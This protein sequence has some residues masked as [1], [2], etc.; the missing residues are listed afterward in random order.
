MVKMFYDK[1]NMQKPRYLLLFGDGSYDNRKLTNTNP[2]Y[3]LTY[4]S[5]NSLS[6]TNSYV[7]DDFFG[8]LDENEGDAFLTGKVD[9]GIGRFP[10]RTEDEAIAILNKIKHYSSSASYGEWKNTIC[11]IADDADK[12][13]TS[14]MNQANELSVYVA[15]NYKFLNIEKIYLDA[16]PQ[17]S[18]A[19]GQRYTEIT[20]ATHI[21]VK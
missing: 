5:K 1:S 21:L 16:F 12:N 15:N 17:I 14:H 11:F 8:L 10:V 13:E 19:T 20:E 2:C 3:V 9:I 4:Q 18:T 6:P 7:S